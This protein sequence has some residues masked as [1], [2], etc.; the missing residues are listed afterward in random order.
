M[1][2][3]VSSQNTM[4]NQNPNGFGGI[5]RI[6]MTDNGRVIYQVVDGTGQNALKM[7]VAQKDSDTFERSYNTIMTTGPKLQQY[8]Q[9]TP[10][11]KIKK[12]QKAS[13]W[14]IAGC[15]LLGGSLGLLKTKGNGFWGTMKQ[16][17]ITILGAGVG[18]FGGAFIASKCT[19]PP[20]AAEFSKATQ[21]LSK[22]DIQPV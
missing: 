7:S 5:S 13:K 19:T 4:Q 9:N 3:N 1:V 8:M 16:V 20:G 2:Q 11:E 10:P 22:L 6:G 15:A 21:A 18:L 12:R 17:G 14:I